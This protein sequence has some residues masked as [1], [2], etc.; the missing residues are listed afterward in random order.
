M[1]EDERYV[2]GPWQYAYRR[3]LT[4]TP[5]TSRCAEQSGRAPTTT[6]SSIAGSAGI[7]TM[8]DQPLSS[9]FVVTADERLVGQ[10]RG[11]P[12]SDRKRVT[13]QLEPRCHPSSGVGQKPNA[14]A[15]CRA[16]NRCELSPLGHGARLAPD[17]KHFG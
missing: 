15:V 17:A 14:D 9:R 5:L 4:I 2:R 8:L 16:P 12:D 7:P 1:S 11:P 6:L 3:V 13:H 10:H